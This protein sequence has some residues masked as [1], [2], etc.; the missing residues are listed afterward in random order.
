MAIARVDA[1]ESRVVELSAEHGG[2]FGGMEEAFL[3]HA[4]DV[5]GITE[6]K[7]SSFEGVGKGGASSTREA[8]KPDGSGMLAESFGTFALGDFGA[9]ADQAGVGTL[10]FEIGGDLL[11]GEGEQHPCGD[12]VIG[13]GVDQDERAR[14]A[15]VFVRIEEQRSVAGQG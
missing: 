9:G 8:G 7:Q 5:A 14:G 12:G 3:R 13:E 1:E 6:V 2:F 4:D 15:V 11:G 10:L